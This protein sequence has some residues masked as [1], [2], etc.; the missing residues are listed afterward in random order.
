MS[1]EWAPPGIDVTVPSVARV[2]DFMLGG[3]DNFAVDRQ[4]AQMA[5]EIVP[6]APMS[7]R[8]NREFLR[9]V[10]RMLAADHGIRQ[11]LDIG[12]G[13][14]S[15]GN[16]HE[17][18]QRV[19]PA[20]RVV[21]VDN[22]PIV[23]VHSRAMLSGNPNTAVI[24]ADLRDP[25]ALLAGSEVRDLLNFDEPVGLLL[26]AILHHLR[27]DED[28]GGIAARLID[29]LAPGSFVAI[30]HFCNTGDE[31]PELTAKSEAVEKLFNERLGTGR[32]RTKQEILS[33]FGGLELLDPGVVPL[34]M[35]RPEVT[36]PTDMAEIHHSF[37]GGLARKP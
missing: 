6:D 8:S 3:K 28:P 18:A 34:P 30:S 37:V 23:L 11:F 32:W 1:D 19:D 16:V 2:Y 35:W 24:Q 22:D 33:F 31:H 21:Y 20:A 29:R 26:F 4:V 10:V 36:G 25:E 12:S 7:G 17:V 13:L 14:P 5:L 15:N 27:D 9:R